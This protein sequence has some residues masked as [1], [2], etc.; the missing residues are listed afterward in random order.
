MIQLECALKKKPRTCWKQSRFIMLLHVST[1]F[2]PLFMTFVEH[3]FCFLP[4]LSSRSLRAE[5]FTFVRSVPSSTYVSSSIGRHYRRHLTRFSLKALS[6]LPPP[7]LSFLLPAAVATGSKLSTGRRQPAA[8]RQKQA[9]AE[10]AVQLYRYL[11][12]SATQSW[13]N[14]LLNGGLSPQSPSKSFEQLRTWEL[15]RVSVF[16]TKTP[17]PFQFVFG[18]RTKRTLLRI[19]LLVVSSNALKI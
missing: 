13:A 15:R 9:A 12:P 8:V 17:G 4:W 6:A 18:T 11:L 16:K 19:H 1:V 3:Q 2:P 10:S 7:P 5:F 14:Q